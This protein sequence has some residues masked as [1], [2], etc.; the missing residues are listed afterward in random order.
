[1][2]FLLPFTDFYRFN[3][4]KIDD[5]CQ[6]EL[7]DGFSLTSGEKR[8][9]YEHNVLEEVEGEKAT[10]LETIVGRRILESRNIWHRLREHRLLERF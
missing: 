2:G 7:V 3:L 10:P 9:P 6:G 5:L 1:M 4:M 8:C